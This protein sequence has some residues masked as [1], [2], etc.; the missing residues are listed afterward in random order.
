MP[1]DLIA[2]FVY[3][4]L[5]R[6]QVRESCWPT[7]PVAVLR[8]WTHGQLWDLGTFPAMVPHETLKVGGELW[9]FAAKQQERINGVLD[10]VEGAPRLYARRTVACETLDGQEISATTYLYAR[11]ERLAEQGEIVEPE[12]DGFCR[13]GR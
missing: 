11:P 4:T 12:E 8:G 7:R 13:W 3:G 9:L 6:N 10:E 5:C 1:E 2:Y